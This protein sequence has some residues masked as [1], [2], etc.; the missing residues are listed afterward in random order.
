MSYTQ[1][2]WAERVWNPVRGCTK[3]SQG[4]KRCYA[5]RWHHRFS[6][7]KKFSEIQLLPEK[8]NE[9]TRLRKP[10]RIFV[11]SMSDLFHEQVPDAFIASAFEIMLA[12][13]Q[14]NYIVLTKRA[15]RLRNWAAE[16][17]ADRSAVPAHI[18]IG[19]SIE[20]QATADERVPLLLDAP[21]STRIISAE[22]LLGPINAPWLLPGWHDG[23]NGV[24]TPGI[25]WLIV[26]GESGPG[27]RPMHAD[28][29]RRLHEQATAAGTPFFFK[30][31]GEHNELGERVGKANSGR[32]LAGREWSEYPPAAARPLP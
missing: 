30:Q 9:P 26:G 31:W 3:I 1:I 13:R 22:P 25:D 16:F 5:E 32:T 28:W 21:V 18:W 19:V 29:V 23:P 24:A 15:E 12:A 6:A 14:H 7:G 11:N 27:A 8:L 2:E 20:D 10:A 17:S 4:C